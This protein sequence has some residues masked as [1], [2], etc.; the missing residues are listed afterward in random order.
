MKQNEI[1]R[2]YIQW[3]QEYEEN[4]SKL[5]QRVEWCQFLDDKYKVC[6]LKM[7]TN[8]I[9]FLLKIV[10]EIDSLQKEI[11]KRRQNIPQTYKEAVNRAETIYEI[12]RL[13]DVCLNLI[14]FSFIFKLILEL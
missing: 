6:L 4:R 3:Q 9:Y 7:L 5:K 13:Y 10:Y 11:D 8:N 12:N 2:K 1:D 14:Y